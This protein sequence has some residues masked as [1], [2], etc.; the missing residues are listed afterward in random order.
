MRF[1]SS[2]LRQKIYLK[3][4][5]SNQQP[6]FMKFF[7]CHRQLYLANCLQSQ[8]YGVFLTQ[9]SFL[10]SETVNL[11][12]QLQ[13]TSAS[14]NCVCL[15]LRR[16]FVLHSSTQMEGVIVSS[17]LIFSTFPLSSL[18]PFPYCH[19]CFLNISQLD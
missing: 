4:R 11:A 6:K 17:L 5:L 10:C 2:I 7:D 12:S 15:T 19:V 13:D 14:L 16:L 8:K 1:K 18:F 9:P 3:G